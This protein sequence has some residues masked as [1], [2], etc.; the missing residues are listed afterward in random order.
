MFVYGHGI[1]LFKF[2]HIFK[3]E[4]RVH[5]S[6]T[7]LALYNIENGAKYFS[8]RLYVCVLWKLSLFYLKFQQLTAC[9]WTM[10]LRRKIKHSPCA[11]C[12]LCKGL[13]LFRFRWTHISFNVILDVFWKSCL[14]IRGKISSENRLNDSIDTSFSI[15]I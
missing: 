12:S 11:D 14:L 6:S 5:N 9:W 4:I 10:Y 3:Y 2:V 7:Y 1:R 8:K 15:P 13:N